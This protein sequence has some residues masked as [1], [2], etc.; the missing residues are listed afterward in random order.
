MKII[1]NFNVLI[2]RH[3]L[4]NGNEKRSVTSVYF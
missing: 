1:S 3:L 4:L 2:L